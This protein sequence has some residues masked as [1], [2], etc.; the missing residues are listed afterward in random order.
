M[1]KRD[2]PVT[3][4]HSIELKGFTREP[5]EE[6]LETMADWF[7]VDGFEE[8]QAHIV[9]VVVQVETERGIGTLNCGEILLPTR[10]AS[11]AAR[12]KLTEG[13]DQIEF[14]L[15]RQSLADVQGFASVATSMAAVILD[16]PDRAQPVK[17][18][19][20]LH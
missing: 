8:D 20:T 1:T 15:S 14:A 6:D 10:R 13:A 7:E 12:R 4:V 18:R 3:K 16:T 9:V 2:A 17:Y 19:P 5:N 11:E